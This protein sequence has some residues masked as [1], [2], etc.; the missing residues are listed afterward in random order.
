MRFGGTKTTVN[1]SP[2]ERAAKGSGAAA[3]MNDVAHVI[4][5]GC[6]R[7]VGRLINDGKLVRADW[8]DQS[9]SCANPWA[10]RNRRGTDTAALTSVNSAHNNGLRF[11][12]KRR[13]GLPDFGGAVGL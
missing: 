2:L 9:S 11:H 4:S 3:P 7:R 1:P 10:I 8:Q 12:G 13:T 6:Q 5:A